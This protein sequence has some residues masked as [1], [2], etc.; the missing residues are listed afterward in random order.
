MP[1]GPDWF[2][3]ADI[4]HYLRSELTPRGTEFVM[5]EV[6]GPGAIVR[7]WSA[8]AGRRVWRVYLD[9]KPEPV[10]EAKG[11]NLLDG[12]KGGLPE[13]FSDKR[14]FGYNLYLPVPFQNGCKV[15]VSFPSGKDRERPPLMYYHVDIRTF[16][17]ET[18]VQTFT[19]DL[20]AADLEKVQDAVSLLARPRS[21]FSDEE[22]TD[23]H[24]EELPAG[25]KTGLSILG[26]GAIRELKIV[27]EAD[28]KKELDEFLVKS[29]LAITFDNA[30]APQVRSPL[31]EFFGAGPGLVPYQSLPLAMEK[32]QNRAVLT[33]RW[34]MPFLSEAGIYLT[35]LSE[36]GARVTLEATT[37]EWDWGKDSLFFH[38]GY[39]A[40]EKIPTRPESDITLLSAQGPGRYVG[41]ELNVRN[42]LE[43]FW[44]GEGDEKVYVDGENFPSI[45]GT[46]TEDYFGYAWCVQWFRFNHA[47][48]GVPKD[49]RVWLVVPQTASLMGLFPWGF[50][51]LDKVVPIKDTTSQYRWHIIDD[52]PFE[53]SIQFDLEVLHHRKTVVD[54]AAVAFWYAA[55]GATDDAPPL[56]LKSREIW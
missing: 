31:G 33:S 53:K 17:P 22:D 16:P 32:D 51:L 14:N 43:H 30:A 41:T 12:L 46:G 47:Y 23:R 49:S 21:Q 9:G 3:N 44:W 19:W 7:L 54:M 40:W 39:R 27:V 5:A 15:T 55:P 38:A 6:E 48:H 56:D 29:L 24:T 20:A 18:K 1:G 34:I 2:A 45:F 4:G 37:S 35:N 8:N 26:P 36:A 42:H 25:A 13:V 28:S 10:I 11:K 52:I 50:V